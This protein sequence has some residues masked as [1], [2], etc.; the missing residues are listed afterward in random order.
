MKRIA[1]AALAAT[2][3]L[4]GCA[5]DIPQNPPPTVIV[6]QYD[7]TASPPVL[8]LPNDLAID[9]TTGLLAVPDNPGDPPAT[10]EFNAYLRT[11][12]GFPPATPV[13]AAFSAALNPA[14][15]TVST[16]A[17]AGSVAVFDLKDMRLLGPSDFKPELSSDGTT[18]T[19]KPLTP[20][21]LAHQYL[22]M[23]FGDQDASGVKGGNGEQVVAAPFTFFVRSSTPLLT[24]PN[25]SDT[26]CQCID[27]KTKQANAACTPVLGLTFAQAAQL[28]VLRANFD[29]SLPQLVAAAGGSH[30]RDSLVFLWSFTIASG[31]FAV[32]DPTSGR[33]P[34]PND[35]L[36]D[37]T[38]G[39]VNLPIDPNLPAAQQAIYMGLNTTDGFSTTADANVPVDTFDDQAP[40]NL[41]AGDS[42][43][44]INSTGLLFQPDYQALPEM[45]NN[46]QDYDG[47]LVVRP[48]SALIGDGSEYLVVVTN[49]VT[50]SMGRPLRPSPVM[51]LVKSESPLYDMTTQKSLVPSVLDDGSAAQLEV[52]RSAYV[53]NGLWDKLGQFFKITRDDVAMVWTY[54]TQAEAVPLQALST[55]PTD[56]S[57]PVDVTIWDTQSDAVDGPDVNLIVHGA[58]HTHLAL[59]AGGTLDLTGGKDVD[60]PFVLFLPKAPLAQGAPV[61]IVQHGL[62]GWRGGLPRTLAEP[63]AQKG[64]AVIAIDINYHGTRSICTKDTE[65]AMGG[66]CQM[67]GTCTT[68]LFVACYADTDCNAGGTCD[69]NTHLCSNGLAPNSTTCMTYMKSGATVQDCNPVASGSGFLNFGNLFAARDNFRQ[70]VLDLSQL[71]RVVSATGAGS[72][73]D[74]LPAQFTIDPT[75]SAYVGQS[76]GGIEGSLFTAASSS[77]KVAVLNVPGGRLVDILLTSPAFSP[78]VTPILQANMITPDTKQFYQLTNIFRWIMDPGD[79]INYGRNIINRPLPMNPAKQVIVQEA[80]N[81]MVIPNPTTDALVAEI[82]LPQVMGHVGVY[83]PTVPNGPPMPVSTYFPGAPHGFIYDPTAPG[84]A[85]GV[86]Q[87]VTWVTSGAT[88]ITAP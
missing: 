66:K 57:L 18:L 5:P 31:P 85:T 69:T 8:P 14:T 2:L 41:A 73:H 55:Y 28:E 34:F 7:P 60:I 74:Q 21:H 38:T 61:A 70:H 12:D 58:L 39:K 27:A 42:V 11:L 29:P 68:S 47:L 83:A 84:H 36:I 48:N 45:V 78:L 86:T 15:V 4:G 32:F 77:P 35:V 1:A 23:V 75:R 59:S 52:L 10:L 79:P 62:Y 9:Q 72:L 65:C 24:C 17:Q 71:E 16:S 43:R 64:W 53:S 76:L 3:A 51:Q 46:G 81:D 22:V 49:G 19:V 30:S 63:F 33:I 82:G 6:A 80:G 87:A 37:Q 54:R 56:K 67:D 13:Q 44:L 25:P 40:L 20:W 26:S 88:L 50:D